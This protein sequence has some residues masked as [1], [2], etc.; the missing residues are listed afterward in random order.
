MSQNK[1]VEMLVSAGVPQEEAIDRA[2]SYQAD[3]QAEEKLSKS[4]D[5]LEEVALI[6]REAEEKHYDRLQKARSQGET[7]L[8]ETIAPALDDLL[9][10]QR[11]QNEA[12]AK[13]LTG[14]LELV[15]SL[16]NEVVK[17]RDHQ[18]ARKSTP[19]A[20]SLDI[21][22]SPNEEVANTSRDDLFKAL[23]NTLANNPDRAGELMQATALLEGGA[24]PAVIANR[25]N[26]K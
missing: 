16:R 15:K 14:V 3:N 13:G 12:L 19:L 1:L 6:Q 24:D 10:E 22:P 23:S 2:N 21:I 17:L 8:A 11:A 7:G 18:P 9:V 4:L 20:K 5:I 25:F 26:L